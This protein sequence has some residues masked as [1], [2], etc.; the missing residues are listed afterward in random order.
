M[1]RSLRL[2]PFRPAFAAVLLLA[3]ATGCST[4]PKQQ[5]T[6]MDGNAGQA[7]GPDG[8]PT[9]GVDRIVRE[10][11]FAPGTQDDLRQT[12]GDTVLFGF[13]SAELDNQS[14]AVL[15]RQVTWLERYPA[16]SV[17]VEG[18]AD[19]RGT[20]DYN[21][22]L[23]ERRATAVRNYL[24]AMGVDRNRITTVTFGKERPV[25]TGSTEAAWALNRR[26]VTV[27]N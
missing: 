21:L 15:D 24:T 9:T 16:L 23:G 20:R 11:S 8:A 2:S 3:V 6:D 19:E 1:R 18:H 26:A 14:R 4:T 7:V 27:V 25:A 10:G 12:V 17:T 22:A 5:V 13:D